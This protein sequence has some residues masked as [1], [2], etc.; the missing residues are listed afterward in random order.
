MFAIGLTRFGGPD[1]LHELNLPDPHPGPG[2]V[3]VRVRAAGINPVDTMVRN[4]SYRRAVEGAPPYVPGMDVAGTIDE[5]GP[6]VMTSSLRIGM[7]V[8]AVVNNR[9]SHGAYSQFLCLPAASVVA[10]PPGISFPEAGSFL[11]NAL[12]ARHALDKLALAPGSTLLVIGAAGAVGGYAVALAFSESQRVI[13]VG[14][15][16]DGAFLRASGASEVLVRGEDYHALLRRVHP[17]GVDAVIDTVGLRGGIASLVRDGGRIIVLRNDGETRFDR[18]VHCEFV[19]VRDRVN[20]RAAVARLAQQVSDGLLMS[21][22]AEIF[23]AQD[24][25]AAHRR[26]DQ[27][28]LR[29]RIVLDFDAGLDA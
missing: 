17:Y 26:F 11:M 12:T 18:G 8:V 25:V 7:D 3:R 23:P 5:I 15:A 6:G 20:D 13:A 19:N 9:G 29:G 14:S 10:K 22:V 27:G 2:E 4:G 21:R 16:A 24:A 1:V 28:G